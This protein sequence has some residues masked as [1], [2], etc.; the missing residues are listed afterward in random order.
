MTDIDV[1]IGD[2]DAVV[3]GIPSAPAERISP[4]Y[5]DLHINRDAAERVFTV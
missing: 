2:S 4:V 3:P 5:W 1:M